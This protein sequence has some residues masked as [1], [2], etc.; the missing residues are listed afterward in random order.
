MP[1]VL[2]GYDGVDMVIEMTWDEI[3]LYWMRVYLMSS[4]FGASITST[5]RHLG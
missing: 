1:G 3:H 2:F 4:Q 5:L